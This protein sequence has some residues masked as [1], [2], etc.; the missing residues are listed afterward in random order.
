MQTMKKF[1]KDLIFIDESHFVSLDQW[2]D[3][4]WFPRGTYPL[5][6]R[7]RLWR[8]QSCSLLMAIGCAG[9]LHHEILVKEVGCGVKEEQ[10]MQ[11][12]LEM[13]YAV[14]LKYIFV[15]DNASTHKSI[16]SMRF[17][18]GMRREGRC[19]LFQPKYCP[20]LNPIELVFGFLKKR[21]KYSFPQRPRDLMENVEMCVQ[22]LT[23]QNCSKSIHHIF[24]PIP[25][26]E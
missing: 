24:D 23:W 17:I 20:E 16:Y 26:I 12:L 4:G 5:A 3:H 25:D 11:F 21:L 18:D 9:V 14:D 13:I 19:I 1:I 8:K 2:R 22:T 7:Q 10:F 6:F 15:M